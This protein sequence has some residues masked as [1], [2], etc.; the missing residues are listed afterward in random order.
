MQASA[1]YLRCCPSSGVIISVHH[2]RYPRCRGYHTDH[3]K[4]AIPLGGRERQLETER[5]ALVWSNAAPRHSPR[6]FACVMPSR[7]HMR[8]AR[9]VAASVMRWCGLRV[10]RRRARHVFAWWRAASVQPSRSRTPSSGRMRS[11]RNSVRS[12]FGRPSRDRTPARPSRGRPVA[13]SR[14][15]RPSPRRGGRIPPPVAGRTP[16]FH[17]VASVHSS[18][19]RAPLAL[20]RL[21]RLRER[22]SRLRVRARCT[23]LPS[24]AS[25]A[26]RPRAVASVAPATMRSCLRARALASDPPV[27]PPPSPAPP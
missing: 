11:G 23:R 15:S 1:K 24:H 2:R 16:R 4:V 25:H 17:A 20:S 13:R 3:P 7:A 12:Q 27:P 14:P 18:R 26:A 21:S 8:L 22:S 10:A 9:R 6:R 19:G 5:G